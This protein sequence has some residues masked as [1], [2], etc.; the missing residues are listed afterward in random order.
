M[1]DTVATV[2]PARPGRIT[3]HESFLDLVDQL[4][5]GDLTTWQRLYRTALAD[6][7]M[8]ENIA[9]AAQCVDPDFVAAGQVWR[10]LV[11]RMPAV[12]A[13]CAEPSEPAPPHQ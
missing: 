12:A 8:R 9:R 11:S 2:T 13:R 7:A 6:E 4:A 3:E 1:S 10:T 5:Y